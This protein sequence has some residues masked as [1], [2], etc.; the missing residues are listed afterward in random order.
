MPL[1][2]HHRHVRADHLPQ[3]VHVVL[4]DGREALV[5]IADL[6]VTADRIKRREIVPALEWVEKNRA[7]LAAKWKELNP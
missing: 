4:S 5:E 2:L 1:E 6:T 7:A 3:H